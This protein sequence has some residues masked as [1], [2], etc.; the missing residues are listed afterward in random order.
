MITPDQVRKEKAI[1]GITGNENDDLIQFS[2]ESAEE[3]IKNYCHIDKVPEGLNA[4]MYRMAADIYRNEQFGQQDSV[5]RVTSISEG[6][7]TTSF[8][9]MASE[10]AKSLLKDYDMALRQYRRVVFR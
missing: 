10:F 7:T 4:T 6:D 2:L 5:S 8:G 1:L 9:G 3:T